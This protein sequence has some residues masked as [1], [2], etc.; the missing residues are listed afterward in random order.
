MTSIE[1]HHICFSVTKRY[2]IE[3]FAPFARSTVPWLVARSGHTCVDTIHYH[4]HTTRDPDE[5]SLQG[6]IASAGEL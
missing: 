5:V 2:P 3:A 6:S 1:S 4:G